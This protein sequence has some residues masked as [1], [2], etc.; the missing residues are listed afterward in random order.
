[1]AE[2][3]NIVGLISY[4]HLP[5]SVLKHETYKDLQAAYSYY[6][7]PGK[8]SLKQM[9]EAALILAKKEGFDVFNALDILDNLSVFE[10]LLFKP[11]DGFLHYY[12]YN[13]KLHGHH[14]QPNEIGKVLV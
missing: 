3:P 2:G 7:I 6:I 12:M 10:D 11:G 13:W 14:L 4:Y 5:S 9:Y 8:Y 1:M